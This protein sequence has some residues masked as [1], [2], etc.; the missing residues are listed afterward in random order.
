MKNLDYLPH[1]IVTRC[2]KFFFPKLK[3]VD[4][5]NILQ[6][7]ALQEELEIDKDALKLIASRSDRSLRD[8]EMTLDQLSLLGQRISLPLVQE[9]VSFSLYFQGSTFWLFKV[10]V[11]DLCGR[12]KSL[13]FYTSE[14][15]RFF[16]LHIL[17]EKLKT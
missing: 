10:Q 5:I 12:V 14:H 3:D 2:H 7:I 15:H 1:T 8:A 9:L 13:K 16:T 4:I 6:S 17:S 11:K